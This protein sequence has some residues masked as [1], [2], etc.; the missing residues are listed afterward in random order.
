ML[1]T[2]IKDFKNIFGQFIYYFVLMVV[3]MAVSVITKNIYY[4]MGAIVFFCVAVP[5][6]ALAYDE[7]DN[8]DKFALASGVTRNQL[9][10]SRYLLGLIVFLPMWAVSFILVAAGGMW[11]IE[12]LSVLL[13]YGGIALLTIDAILPVVLKIGVEKGRLVY[14]LTILIV[15]ALGGVLAFLVEAIGGDSV[16]YSSVAV[17]AL[18]IAGF[19]LSI[20]IA[21]NIY[22][23]KDF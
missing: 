21:C 1:G 2:I 20:K 23:K 17:L 8:W 15:I 3:F 22:R 18:G 10:V 19:F 5:L 4:Y 9:A 11:N 12:N 13:S 14:I 16:L 6:S 7:K